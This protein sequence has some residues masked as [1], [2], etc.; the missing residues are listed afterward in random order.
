MKCYP[1]VQ[2]KTNPRV[3]FTYPQKYSMLRNC[4]V[5]AVMDAMANTQIGQKG[6]S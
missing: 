2:D 4:A 5:A 1:L 3:H 6:R